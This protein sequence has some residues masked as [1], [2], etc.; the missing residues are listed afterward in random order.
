MPRTV[1]RDAKTGPPRI[2]LAS[3]TAPP[4]PAEP[5]SPAA[6]TPLAAAAPAATESAA[7]TGVGAREKERTTFVTTAFTRDGGT[8]AEVQSRRTGVCERIRG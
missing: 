5:P 8:E 1:E 7:A 3:C 4:T 6:A 2:A